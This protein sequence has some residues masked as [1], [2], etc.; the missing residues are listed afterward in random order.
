MMINHFDEEKYVKLQEIN[1]EEWES[2]C[3]MCGA[4]CGSLEGDPCVHLIAREGG[5]YFCEVYDHRF[6]TH[7]TR[8]GET[9]RCVD[10]RN[11]LTKSWPGSSQ[12]GYKK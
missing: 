6:G 2:R 7:K 10:I 3:R 8:S 12:C 9:L 11:I 4:C 5:K 1:K